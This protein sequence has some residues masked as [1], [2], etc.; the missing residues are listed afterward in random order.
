MPS[1]AVRDGGRGREPALSGRARIGSLNII[2]DGLDLLGKCLMNFRFPAFHFTQAP[3]A[4]GAKASRTYALTQYVKQM[5]FNSTMTG[6]IY[7][8][9]TYKGKASG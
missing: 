8:K 1:A 7:M 6:W 2:N 3:V 5:R 9:D 4:P